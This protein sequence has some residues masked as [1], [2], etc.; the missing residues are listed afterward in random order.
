MER[1]AD[2]MER[3]RRY[4]VVLALLMSDLDNFKRINDTHGH[5]AGDRALREV[6]RIL[7][8]E[9]RTV[10]VVARFGG[11]EFVV[12]LPE[13]SEEGAMAFA[14]R[15]RQRIAES[16]ILPGDGSPAFGVTASIGVAWFPSPSVDSA[17]DLIARAD[18]SLYRAKAAGR[19]Q[20]G[21]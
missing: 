11:E 12:V 19:K 16:S 8:R 17:D 5:P 6:S 2:R 21:K 14:E 18:E 7:Q 20:G 4:D 1:L 10:D 3:A 13:T 9:A 15:M